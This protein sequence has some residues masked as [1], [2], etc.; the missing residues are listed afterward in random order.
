MYVDALQCPGCMLTLIDV[1]DV[2]RHSRMSW[3]YVDALQCPG[4]MAMITDVLDVF[5]YS[6]MS[7]MSG[8]QDLDWFIAFLFCLLNHPIC[9][10][11]KWS[12]LCVHSRSYK[13]C[14]LQSMC[15]SSLEGALTTCR[16]GT[17]TYSRLVWKWKNTQIS[18]WRCPM[19]GKMSK[20]QHL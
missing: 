14:D 18:P 4:C 2:W 1:L 12:P 15:R 19:D 7:W 3:M 11:D 6:P 16:L 13:C 10:C 20:D 9:R 17:E 5:Q 8:Y